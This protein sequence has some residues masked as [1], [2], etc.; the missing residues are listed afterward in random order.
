MGCDMTHKPILQVVLVVA[1]IAASIA[2]G[3]DAKWT[4][5]PVMQQRF[6][7]KKR[8]ESASDLIPKDEAI[9]TLRSLAIECH[10]TLGPDDPVTWE[11]RNVLASA[12]GSQERSSEA[13]AQLRI[14]LRVQE[15][16]LGPSHSE[17]LKTREA[18][19]GNLTAQQK[20]S[21]A[22]A[23]FSRVLKA[24]QEALENAKVVI[25]NVRQALGYSLFHQGNYEASKAEYRAVLTEAKQEMEL[26]HSSMRSG[27]YRYYVMESESG[28]ANCL[29]AERKFEE[30]EV[31]LR[32]LLKERE[33]E[34]EMG[35][36]VTAGTIYKLIECLMAQ[37]KRSEAL[38]LAQH[39]YE[40]VKTNEK[41]DG[42]STLYYKKRWDDLKA[43]KK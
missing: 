18:I 12:L 36:L 20:Y 6:D 32:A 38:K 30:A 31:L 39:A 29:H 16:V 35:Y 19:A 25:W 8:I 33:K 15:K 40:I 34:N 43:S 37:G 10:N 42:Q 9:E 28:I 3:E 5:P 11:C 13:E 27:S 4:P 14:I 7:L 1:L 21:E 22:A 2:W 23:E 24:R 17:T 26:G 41:G